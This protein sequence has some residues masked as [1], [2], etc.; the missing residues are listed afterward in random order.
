MQS[1]ERAITP[2]LLST[3]DPNIDDA[4]PVQDITVAL[5]SLHSMHPVR[6]TSILYAAPEDPS[7]LLY[8]LCKRL[9][10]TF[11]QADLMVKDDRPLKLHATILN[12]IY[13]KSSS[14][15]GNKSGIKAAAGAGTVH[16]ELSHTQIE[17]TKPATGTEMTLDRHDDAPR[18]REASAA[19]QRR[20]GHGPN[21]KAPIRIDATGL[22]EQFKDFVWAE[23]IR[24][25]KIAICKMGAKKIFDDAGNL[26][27]EAY[28]EVASVP[29][30]SSE[31]GS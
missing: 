26:I 21:A 7:N 29:L 30:Q 24:I 31:T 19:Q 5:K 10:D 22:L 20:S 11:T 28:E 12:T 6:K 13:A 16:D 18:D 8:P 23:D 27:D 2:P 14:R 9:R 1:L 3:G 17:P 15:G 25:E 4:P